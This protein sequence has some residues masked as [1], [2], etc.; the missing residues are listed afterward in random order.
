MGGNLTTLTDVANQVLPIYSRLLLVEALPKMHFWN[1][2]L[3]DAELKAEQQP[4]NEV[5]FNYESQ[6]TGSGDI[7]DEDT[8]IS[9]EKR[10][11]SKTSFL[12]VEKGHGFSLSRKAEVASLVDMLTRGRIVLGNHYA[13]EID[14]FLRDIFFTTGNKYYAKGNGTS[15]T[16]IT[17]TA[18]ILNVETLDS[19]KEKMA[20]LNM[21]M[22]NDGSRGEYWIFIGTNRQIRQINRD[23]LLVNKKNY[24][25]PTDWI[26]G[27]VGMFEN[28]VFLSS[29]LMADKIA[30]N[31]GASTANVH[32]GLMI[33][34]GAV[35]ILQSIA[36]R[37]SLLPYDERLRTQTML[38]YAL[39]GAGILQ[40]YIYEVNTTD[41]LPSYA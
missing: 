29:T 6:L 12:L 22:F 41:V 2:C 27:E 32:K 28:V 9:I 33:A 13:K 24:A 15:G 20:N 35:G 39:L 36:M 34:P 1:L 8:P 25:S 38:W 19:V 30:L 37:L 18:S 23:K 40:D 26:N 4:G 11:S 31:A 21:P 3:R 17:D 7:P 14:K 16:A 5:L 10:G